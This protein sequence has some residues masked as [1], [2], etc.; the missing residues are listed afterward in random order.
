[1]R[2]S[3]NHAL[4]CATRWLRALRVDPNRLPV[5]PWGDVRPKAAGRL[6]KRIPVWGRHPS[7]GVVPD[8]SA[9]DAGLAGDRGVAAPPRS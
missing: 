6:P 8:G 5:P 9:R 4:R 1:M 2:P 7:L 3:I